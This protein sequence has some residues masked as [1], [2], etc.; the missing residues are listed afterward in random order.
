MTQ[1][2]NNI[3]DAVAEIVN[4]V[5]DDLSLEDRVAIA[6]LEDDQIEFINKLLVGYIQ[7]KLSELS[8]RQNDEDLTEPEAIVK[9]VWNRLRVTHKLRIVE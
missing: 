2:N 4:Q 6:N 8:I 5:I 7:N 3:P 1:T 9:E